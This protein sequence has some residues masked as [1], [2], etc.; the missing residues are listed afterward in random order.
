[1]LKID[2][3]KSNQ[4]AEVLNGG[5]LDS[6]QAYHVEHCGQ[7]RRTMAASLL[8]GRI[9]RPGADAVVGVHLESGSLDRLHAAAYEYEELESHGLAKFVASMRHLNRCDAC[10][11][12]FF[13]LHQSLTPSPHSVAAALSRFKSGQSAQ[14]VGTLQVTRTLER[15][16][17]VFFADRPAASWRKT[18]DHSLVAALANLSSDQ[19]DLSD[20][21]E[22]KVPAAASSHPSPSMMNWSSM[23]HTP[24]VAFDTFMSRE[25]MEPA[26][27]LVPSIEE[28][29]ESAAQQAE[30]LEK[31]L[32]EESTEIARIRK[33]L[34]VSRSRADDGGTLRI[35]LT[36]FE[37]TTEIQEAHEWRAEFLRS[38]MRSLKIELD[39]I[40]ELTQQQRS[41]LY[42]AAP[43][44]VK[45]PDLLLEFTASWQGEAGWLAVVARDSITHEL[46][47]GVELTAQSA[48]YEPT[49][50]PESTDI[51]GQARVPLH[52]GTTGLR[53]SCGPPA[54]PWFISI[55]VQEQHPLR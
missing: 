10:F 51:V 12:R 19:I 36:D 20:F 13:A 11:A 16:Q 53:I 5:R 26:A 40:D 49:A 44:Y 6:A 17:Q 3:L 8:A 27:S 15:L 43:Q 37:R 31:L 55:E 46:R 47:P 45:L 35:L 14:R 42:V 29:R 7:C 30:Q 38:T 1:M 4:L 18:D 39:R 41:Q 28:L 52:A 48:G 33:R 25:S 22:S 9:G 54:K 23:R 32:Q 24:S 50:P 21:S 2:H 34:T